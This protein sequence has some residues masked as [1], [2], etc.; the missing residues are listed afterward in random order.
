M[1]QSFP[2]R[3]DFDVI[4]VGAGPSGTAAAYALSR[5]GYRILLTERARPAQD[6]PCAGG[7][8][9]KTLKLLPWAA[10]PVVERAVASL[11]MGLHGPGKLKSI[12]LTADGYVCSF[13]VRK[14]FDRFN[15]A[16]TL[17][18]GVEFLRSEP[19]GA[20]ESLSDSARLTLGGKTLTARYVI[21]ADGANSTVRRLLGPASWYR[22]GFAVE[23]IV[24]YR[25]AELEPT[26][27]FLFGYV[28]NGYGW[29]FPKGDHV[30]VGLYSWDSSVSLSKSR[31]AAY[32]RERLGT[33]RIEH[34]AGYPIGFGGAGHLDRHER[35]VLVG[36]AAGLAEPLL[37]EG[38]HNAIKSGQ[39]A[40]AAIAACGDGRAAGLSDAYRIALAPLRK[41]LRRCEQL[42]RLFYAHLEGAGFR[43]LSM[44]IVNGALMRGFAA[45]KTMHEL[46]N[47]FLLS[48]FFRPL[49]P[50]A[51]KE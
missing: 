23:G 29:L 10:G 22:R 27:E 13:A 40:A 28:K 41:D 50:V 21:G 39:A 3:T 4:V 30:N 20:I 36:D 17:E 11:R 2:L 25:A 12:T 51:G 33:D 1:L 16:K 38:I 15:L 19:V 26:A 35:V 32:V 24:D 5:L 43:A 49:M 47:Q 6:K 18:S 9:P 44:P 14:Q 7:L 46:T 42:K 45:G 37:G 34:I 48:A 8:T 31:L